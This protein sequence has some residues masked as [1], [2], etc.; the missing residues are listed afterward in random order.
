MSAHVQVAESRSPWAGGIS[1]F[2]VSWQ[3]LMMWIFILSDAF[4]FGSF[5]VSYA[6]SR[7]SVGTWVDTGKVFA[8][9]IGGTEVPL[10]LIAIMTFILVSSSGT[11][12]LAVANAYERNK[13]ATV[14]YLTLTMLL[15][16]TFV[17]CQA[18]EWTH[19]IVD[20]GVRPWWNPFGPPQFGA[21]FFTLT[22]FHGL[23]VLSGVI[24][25]GIIARL[26]AR[27]VYDRRG[28]YEAVEVAG[29]YWHFLTVVWIGLLVLLVTR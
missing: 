21:Y 22:G 4:I 27:G 1:P 13:R 25:L 11:M 10:L 7:A 14:R 24:Y 15:G 23:H 16:L 28:S 29:L 3:K 20:Y 26:V 2:G 12:A 5:L 8:L 9:H 18:Y 6:T 19:L 17:G